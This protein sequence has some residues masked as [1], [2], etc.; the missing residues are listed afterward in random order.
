M[1]VIAHVM[2][3]SQATT[4]HHLLLTFSDILHTCQTDFILANLIIFIHI[5]QWQKSDEDSEHNFC[6]LKR[7]S[8]GLSMSALHDSNIEK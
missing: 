7:I 2:A 3:S 4:N 1:N 5:Q 6:L 8:V